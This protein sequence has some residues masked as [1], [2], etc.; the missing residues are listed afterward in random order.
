MDR[1]PEREGG[2]GVGTC[3]AASLPV[4]APRASQPAPGVYK[5]S[6]Q[7]SR[8]L[9]SAGPVGGRAHA[10]ALHARNDGLFTGTRSGRGNSG[11]FLFL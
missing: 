11:R 10:Y 7:G 2:E 6:P 5:P 4:L 1:S 3:T 8:S 9:R